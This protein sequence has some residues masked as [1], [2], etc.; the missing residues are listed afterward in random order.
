[1][2]QELR[3]LLISGLPDI[4]AARINWGEAPQGTIR[5]FVVLNL[6]SDTE[7]TTM[8]GR[9]GL[10]KS[11]VQVDCYGPDYSTVAAM[12]AAV[13]DALHGYHG[14]GFQGIFFAGGRVPREGNDEA[15]A[16]YRASLDFMTHW[17]PDNG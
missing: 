4:G 10:R 11:R 6:I 3:A 14:G 5:P 7:G 2:E 1:M 17:R 16:I 12:M 15:S 8:Q 13:K 9:D